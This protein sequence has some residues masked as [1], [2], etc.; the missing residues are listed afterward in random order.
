MCEGNEE[1][2]LELAL[3]PAQ[4]P[5]REPQKNLQGRLAETLGDF[6][7]S[8]KE[9]EAIGREIDDRRLRVKRHSVAEASLDYAIA[10][11]RW[12]TEHDC[13]AYNRDP[14]VRDAIAVIG[15]D[16][17]LIHVKITRAL[18]GR[19]EYPRGAPFEKSAVQ[20]DWNGSAKV[21]LIS[22]QRSEN[23][24]GLVATATDDGGARVLAGCL[25]NL[26]LEMN[27]EFPRATEFRRPGFDEPKRA[28]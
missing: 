4:V 2:A 23:A 16:S 28:R 27:R 17:H 9:L 25:E 10:A 1:A 21:A 8:A 6:D 7:P 13:G 15:W 20:S 19:D 3:G 26:R 22:L 14:A 18:N 5:G 24:W 11:H 12:L